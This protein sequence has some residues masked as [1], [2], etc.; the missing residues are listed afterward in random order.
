MSGYT[1]ANLRSDVQDM[2][3][4]RMRPG[5]ALKPSRPCLA[6][7]ALDALRSLESSWSCVDLDN[8]GLGAHFNNGPG[9]L[10]DD[11]GRG[12]TTI[13]HHHA[14]LGFLDNSATHGSS[15]GSTSVF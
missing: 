2:A 7:H 4:G 1:K 9:R 5:I 6:L 12:D 10:S 8:P 3:Q 15:G 13:G 14:F 11:N